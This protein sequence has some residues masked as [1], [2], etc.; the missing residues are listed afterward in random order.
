MDISFV[1]AVYNRLELTKE[2]YSRL[3]KIYPSAPLVI[4]SGGSSDGTKEWLESLD[5]DNLSYIHDDE[6]LT[7]SD[8]YNSGIKLVDTEKLVLI[9]ND[10]VIGEG[11]LEAIERLLTE[12]MILSYTTIVPPIFKDHTRPGKVLLDLGSGFDN[13][14][15]VQFNEYV[16]K[17][18]DDDTLSNGAV[19]F[20]SAYKKTFLEE[21]NYNI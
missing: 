10:M 15:S 2:C 14:N 18:K 8:N 3:R 1:L 6:R 17:W 21:L 16:Q 13:F 12:N 9:H 4:S 5:D 20:M 19:F 11:F 7:F